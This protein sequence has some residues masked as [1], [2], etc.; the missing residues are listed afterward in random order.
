MGK[1]KDKRF[2]AQ[3]ATLLRLLEIKETFFSPL[4]GKKE[5]MGVLDI[6]G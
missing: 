2:R 4:E 1:I 6:R 3:E 5:H